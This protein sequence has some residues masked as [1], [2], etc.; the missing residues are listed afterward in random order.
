MPLPETKQ[1]AQVVLGMVHQLI[2]WYPRL[3]CNT[4]VM[5]TLTWKNVKFMDTVNLRK[6]LEELKEYLAHM[7]PLSPVDHQH[8]IE[9]FTYGSQLRESSAYHGTLHIWLSA[10]GNW[11]PPNSEI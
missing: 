9:L 6:E 1:E 10:Q 3:S 2:N 5:Q 7:L 4:R 8:P 11:L